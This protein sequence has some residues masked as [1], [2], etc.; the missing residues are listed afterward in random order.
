METKEQEIAAIKGTMSI[1]SKYRVDYVDSG[2]PRWLI[3]AAFVCMVLQAAIDWSPLLKWT[4]AHTPWLQAVVMTFGSLVMYV[5]L[6]RGSKRLYRPFTAGWWTVIL[7]NILGFLSL[8]FPEF[9]EYLGLP[10]AVSL[11]LVYLPFGSLIAYC[12]RGRLRHVGIWMVLYILV[13]SLV[14]VM[15][16]LLGAPYSDLIYWLMEF[17]TI[18][19]ILV[20]AWVL[21]RVLVR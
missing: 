1:E 2:L 8:S 18:G 7:L 10:I 14:P 3:E 21:R 20:Y 13:S 11:M 16:Y 9:D 5:A 15:W 17:S 4:K 12:Y 19:V 6:L